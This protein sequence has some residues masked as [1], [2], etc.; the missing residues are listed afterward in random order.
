[1]RTPKV[2][3]SKPIN[4]TT[5]PM[6]DMITKNKNPSRISMTVIEFYQST[7]LKR[8]SCEN[9]IREPDSTGQLRLKLP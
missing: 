3:I 5:K 7:S 1:M 9:T 4:D 6:I 2:D 8:T